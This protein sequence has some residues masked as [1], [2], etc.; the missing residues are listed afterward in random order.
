L[1]EHYLPFARML[2]AKCYARRMDNSVT[3]D[4]YL[5]YAR[6]GLVESVDRF[7]IS[8]GVSFE[9]YSAYRIRGSILNG[10]ADTSETA[11]QRSF[12]HSRVPERVDSLVAHSRQ[13]PERMSLDDLAEITVAVTLGLILEQEEWE[14]QD[15][16]VQ[17]NPYACT[18]LDQFTQRVKSLV[19]SLPEREAQIIRRH[20]FE[21]REFQSIAQDYGI[22]KGRVS[23][24]HAKALQR[25][26]ALLVERPKLDRKL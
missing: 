26:K 18:E 12:W 19:G 9:S 22:T 7:D 14:V 15:E 24:I 25:L 4:D 16:S 23:Q 10:L 1:I 5:Q 20:Y 2:A 21:G 13:V 8:K 17:A 3:F 11:A 6:V